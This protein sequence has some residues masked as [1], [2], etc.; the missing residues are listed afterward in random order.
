VVHDEL[1]E[2]RRILIGLG[3]FEAQGQTLISETAAQMQGV[4][5]GTELRLANPL[6]SDMSVLRPALSP[7]LIEAL[8]HNVHH[9]TN[10]VALF[11]IGRVFL[12]KDGAPREERRLAL[13]LTGRRSPPFWSGAERDAKYDSYDLKGILEEFFDQ[14]GIRAVGYSRRADASPLYAE[15]AA[16]Q[17]GRQPLGELGQLLPT[18]ARRYD[19]RDPVLIAELNLDQILTRRNPAKAFKS[20]PAFPAIQRDVAMLLPETSTHDAVLALVK[21]TKPANLESAELFDI[22]RGQNV[23]A[24]QKSV[25]YSFTYRNVERTLTDAE[26]NAAHDNLVEQLKAKL[27]AVVRQ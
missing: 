16:I 4:A 27:Q 24:G 10:D 12:N 22:Y 18:I 3:L 7:G 19:L 21:Q 17:L 2:V 25:A 23:P 8:R 26:V 11:E 6:S 9:R 14:I 13:A 1:A 20:L 5:D 15:S